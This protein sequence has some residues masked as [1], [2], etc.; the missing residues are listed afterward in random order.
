MFKGLEIGKEAVK[1][2]KFVPVHPN[3]AIGDKHEN[4]LMLFGK[5]STVYRDTVGEIL[6][7]NA[8]N[9]PDQNKRIEQSA[10][11]IVACC[12][13]WGGATDEKGKPDRYTPEKL[14]KMLLNDEFRWIRIQADSY[15][16]SDGGYFPKP[17]KN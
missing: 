3:P 2:Q 5:Y 16:L 6:R 9:E 7:E 15:M 13:G 11:L 14:T 17:S 12:A 8:D 4:Y 1:A 10:K